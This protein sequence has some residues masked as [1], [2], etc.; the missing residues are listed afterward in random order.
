MSLSICGVN[1]GVTT[2]TFGKGFET[3]RNFFGVTGDDARW[4]RNGN[5]FE[6]CFCLCYQVLWKSLP[7]P[8]YGRWSTDKDPPWT[9]IMC[10]LGTGLLGR[11]YV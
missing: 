6:D 3:K 2:H 8:F 5:K 9:L 7:L 10:S 4:D 11:A 1:F